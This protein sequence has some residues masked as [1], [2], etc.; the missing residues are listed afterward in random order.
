MENVN[1]SQLCTIMLSF[2][3]EYGVVNTLLAE[4]LQSFLDKSIFPR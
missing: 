1:Y 2:S 4:S 3:F